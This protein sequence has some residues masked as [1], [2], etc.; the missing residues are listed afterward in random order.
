[1]V[2]VSKVLNI[3]SDF[4]LIKYTVKFRLISKKQKKKV[5]YSPRLID[6][7]CGIS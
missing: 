7:F 3:I 2:I 1:M 5:R 4:L 6:N